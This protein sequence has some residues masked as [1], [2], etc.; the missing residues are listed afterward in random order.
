MVPEDGIKS[1]CKQ[2]IFDHVIRPPLTGDMYT[3]WV[4][5]HKVEW[6]LHCIVQ[7][8]QIILFLTDGFNY[9]VKLVEWDQ[10][11]ALGMLRYLGWNHLYLH[12]T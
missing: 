1:E 3:L 8:D 10:L 11:V 12:G 4:D 6:S 2:W 5:E 7:R 9:N